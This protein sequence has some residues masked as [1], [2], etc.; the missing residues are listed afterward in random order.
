M[1]DQPLDAPGDES[2]PQDAE[3]PSDAAEE[4]SKPSES[5]EGA[6]DVAEGRDP[7]VIQREIEQ[8]RAELADTIDAIADRLSPKRAA[9]R[10]AAAVKSQLSNAFTGSDEPPA[11]VLDA[12]PERAEHSTQPALSS[13][14]DATTSYAVRRT[15][16]TDRLLMVAGVAVAVTAVFVIRRRRR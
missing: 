15:L 10:G 14:G 11:S 9:S 12:P 2:V 1:P 16:R 5:E 4:S 7:D 13:G 6:A 8:T 3:A